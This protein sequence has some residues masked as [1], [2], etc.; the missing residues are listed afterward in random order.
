MSADEDEDD[1]I[2][3]HEEEGFL[4]QQQQQ[5]ILDAG[6]DSELESDTDEDV[7]LGHNPEDKTH[8]NHE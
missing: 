2:Y 5:Q 1:K 4:V 6:A 8:S 3:N 7:V